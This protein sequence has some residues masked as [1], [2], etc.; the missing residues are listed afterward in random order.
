MT[1]APVTGGNKCIIIIRQLPCDNK[2]PLAS[3]KP[4]T[5]LQRFK[6]ITSNSA[7]CE[8]G[9]GY[10]SQYIACTI[11]IHV[12]SMLSRLIGLSNH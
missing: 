4:A 5:A 6:I 8:S 7:Q 10:D 9:S 3:L 1:E 12:F 2:T 11:Q